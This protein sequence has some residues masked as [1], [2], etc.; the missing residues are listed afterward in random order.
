MLPIGDLRIN[1]VARLRRLGGMK[2]QGDSDTPSL[3]DVEL[4]NLKDD[5]NKPHFG[6]KC[7]I[8]E[9]DSCQGNGRV[10]LVYLDKNE[11]DIEKREKP[12]IWLL[13]RYDL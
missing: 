1:S 6:V 2:S 13:D 3:L 4:Y 11:T 9:I 5:P 10:C 7:K 8:F 12:K